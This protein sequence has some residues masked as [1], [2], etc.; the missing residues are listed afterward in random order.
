MLE[1]VVDLPLRGIL[2]YSMICD[3]FFF[4]NFYTNYM[5]VNMAKMYILIIFEA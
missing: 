2:V 5:P 4:L 3:F 1:H